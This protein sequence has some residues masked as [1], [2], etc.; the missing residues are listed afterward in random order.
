MFEVMPVPIEFL[1]GLLG[2][3]GIACAHMTGR[4]I[5]GVR[6]G[7]HKPSR[8]YGWIIRTVLCMAA[9]A[10]RHAVDTAAVVIWLL[11]A[12]AFAAGMWAVSRQKKP[13]DLTRTI[14][15]E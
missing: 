14:F 13:E 15:P 10:F 4:S 12:A 2:L 3:I 8:L 9:M 5:I 6:R 11:A 7:W 1:R